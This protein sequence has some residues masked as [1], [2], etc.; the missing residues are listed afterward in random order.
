MNQNSIDSVKRNAI[1]SVLSLFAQS[2][3]SAVLGLVANLVVTILLTPSIYGIYIAVLS[4]NSIL[5]YFSDIG[6]AASLIQKKSI[7]TADISTTFTVQQLLII[8]LIV[9]SFIFTRPITSFYN[10]PSEGV[11]LYWAVLLGFFLSSLKTIP[12][13]FLER[14]IEFQKIV[15][16][17][18]IESTLFY[19]SVIVFA[20]LGYGLTS[21]TISVIIRS[22][23]GVIV[24]YS[25]SFWKPQI[26]FSMKSFRQLISFGLPFQ[27]SS[28]LALFKDDFVILFL[29]KVVGFEVLGY[30]GWAKKW[31][32]APIR[33]V[34][35]NIGKVLFPSIARLQEKTSTVANLIEKMLFYQTSVIAPAMIGAALLMQPIVYLIPKYAKWE[36]ALP[37]FYVFSLSSLIISLAAP[38]V[39]ILNALG[40]AKTSFLF[41]VMFTILTWSLVP[42]SI[43]INQYMGFPI[44]HLIISAS[45]I[46]LIIYV[47]RLIR[48]ELTK[49][50]FQPLISSFI[51]GIFLLYVITQFQMS[52]IYGVVFLIILGAGIYVGSLRFIFKINIVEKLF[53][54]VRQVRS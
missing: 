31:A 21:F 22:V 44:A 51:M 26:G 8:T 11:Y 45:Y 38:F 41:M 30:I 47:K 43:S 48:F 40:K 3:Y 23:V 50:I 29:G 17:Q 37:M 1:V 25:I 9:F 39:S 2:G 53:V 27:G 36:P 13:V 52:S 46:F 18:V 24:M 42:L 14:K 20:L 12:S 19:S 49:S 10:L 34:M 33:I 54:F 6:L 5:N 15:I 4:M 28:F 35:D 32:E 7:D 16:V